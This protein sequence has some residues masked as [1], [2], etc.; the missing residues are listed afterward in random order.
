M[1]R[2]QF[3]KTG[4]LVVGGLALSSLVD[5]RS[6]VRD[7]MA[8]DQ[9]AQE[10]ERRA[11][12]IL[13]AISEPSF[14]PGEFDVTAFGAV[15]DGG[16]DNAG[17][18]AAAVAACAGA[19]GGTVLVP[20]G[21]ESYFLR[22]PV[23]LAGDNLRL[24]LAAGATLKFSTPDQTNPYAQE[25]PVT[26]DEL[27]PLIFAD[28]RTNVGVTGEGSASLIDGQ[29]APLAYNWWSWTGR[30]EHGWEP[31]V[32]IEGQDV[33]KRPTTVYFNQCQNVLIRGV[34]TVSTPKFQFKLRR[35]Q[36]VTVDA[37][38]PMSWN[39]PNNDGID[40]SSCRFV[41]IQNCVIDSGDDCVAVGAGTGYPCRDILMQDCD[42]YHG[43]GALACGSSAAGGISNVVARRIHM[44]D[45]NLQY[46]LRVKLNRQ[47]GGS[48][49]D[50][51][52][53]DGDS[54][55]LKKNVVEVN[56]HYST[57][58]G[59]LV[60]QAGGVRVG[61]INVGAA[62]LSDYA[63]YVRGWPDSCIRGMELA[64]SSIAR[65]RTP[66]LAE[67]V[68]DLVVDNVTVNGQALDSS[69]DIPCGSEG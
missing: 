55:G 36:N 14:P 15:A 56:L 61:L 54:V 60:P 63:L 66:K 26:G 48:A 69:V 4:G 16:T 41:V 32:P 53:Y 50:V 3:L 42:V 19:G 11:T 40:P 9:L 1:T 8:D 52:L 28:G 12:E 46:A 44:H 17:A 6:L 37:V 62:S 20:A 7:V 18:F 64:D 65:A 31:G 25:Y 5:P 21:S 29:A 59:S 24:H 30:P 39:G 47:T 45:P 35:C 51:F 2:K 13:A 10:V 49:Q 68:S 23:E 67:Y 33:A 43:H 27:T 58:Q 34:R 57:D 22:G 38:Q